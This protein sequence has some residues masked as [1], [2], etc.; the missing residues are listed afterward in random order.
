[1]TRL[2]QLRH[3]LRPARRR[4]LTSACTCRSDD[5]SPEMF[6]LSRQEMDPTAGLCRLQPYLRISPLP[7]IFSRVTFPALPSKLTRLRASGSAR[8]LLN[9]EDERIRT[10]QSPDPWPGD[11]GS[12]P[13]VC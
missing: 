3:W 9:L 11:C 4:G 7:V 5:C 6:R 10:N 2:T 13:C 8:R 12:S 1:M